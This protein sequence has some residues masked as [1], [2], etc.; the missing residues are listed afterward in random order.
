[1]FQRPGDRV[2][3]IFEDGLAVGDEDRRQPQAQ[4]TTDTNQ[5][6]AAAPQAAAHGHT[7]RRTCRLHRARRIRPSDSAKLQRLAAP[8]RSTIASTYG[9]AVDSVAKL[10]GCVAAIL[11]IRAYP[12]VTPAEKAQVVLP[13]VEDRSVPTAW[14]ASRS[15]TKQRPISWVTAGA[16][17]AEDWGPVALVPIASLPR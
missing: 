9:V 5:R 7:I 1:V 8:A 12:D 3:P 17:G 16:S 11:A 2:T 4:R 15:V 6:D 14:R 13:E 10:L